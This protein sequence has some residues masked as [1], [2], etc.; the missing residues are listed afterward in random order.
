MRILYSELQGGR[1][2]RDG[3]KDICWSSIRDLSINQEDRQVLAKYIVTQTVAIQKSIASPEE[4]MM[5]KN[6]DKN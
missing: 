3:Y 2:I 1:R 5:P 6:E 4:E